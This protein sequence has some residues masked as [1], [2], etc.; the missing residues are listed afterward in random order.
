MEYA[1]NNRVRDTKKGFLS[2]VCVSFKI[3]IVGE[4]TKTI[5]ELYGIG[6]M[7]KYVRH[8]LRCSVASGP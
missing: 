7:V 1:H 3:N 2:C 5:V 6:Y 4:T 8:F